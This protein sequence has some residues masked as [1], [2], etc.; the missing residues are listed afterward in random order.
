MIRKI[1]LFGAGVTLMAGIALMGNVNYASANH[2]TDARAYTGEPCD[3]VYGDLYTENT[4][5]DRDGDEHTQCVA[6]QPH[7]L[8]RS[9]DTHITRGFL[10]YR[11]G[12]PESPTYRQEVTRYWVED[13]GERY[14]VSKAV[15]ESHN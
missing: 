9:A 2:F 14:E 4:F 8:T 6:S 7:H 13:D 12:N 10:A 1:A 3:E 5:T 15:Y 11:D